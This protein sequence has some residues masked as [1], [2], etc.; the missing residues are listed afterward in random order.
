MKRKFHWIEDSKSVVLFRGP[1][2]ACLSYYK[3][4]GGSKSGLHIFYSFDEPPSVGKV[5]S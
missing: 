2:R 5:N 3:K 1:E 4:H